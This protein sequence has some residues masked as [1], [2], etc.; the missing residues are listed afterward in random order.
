MRLKL[1]ITKKNNKKMS[2]NFTLNAV[3]FSLVFRKSIARTK[4]SRIIVTLTSNSQGESTEDNTNESGLI[5][6]FF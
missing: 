4:E 6:F 1:V 2:I 3:I 5:V